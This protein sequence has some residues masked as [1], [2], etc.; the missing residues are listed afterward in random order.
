MREIGHGEAGTN[1]DLPFLDPRR[2]ADAALAVAHAIRRF[3][4]VNGIATNDSMS[5]R[6]LHSI[7]EGQF[8][9]TRKNRVAAW[10]DLSQA[11]GVRVREYSANSFDPSLG[12][13]FEVHFLVSS[14]I[15]RNWMQ[16]QIRPG[17]PRAAT[18]WPNA[19]LR[20]LQ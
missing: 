6:E 14:G 1:P 10:K 9:E 7:L 13:D 20:E 5:D 16:A 12:P 17:L 11:M 4:A 2:A 18:Y 3:A 8:R 19:Q 15:Q